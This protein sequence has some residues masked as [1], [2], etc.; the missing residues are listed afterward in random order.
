M[1][2]DQKK[3]YFNGRIKATN[4]LHH[5]FDLDKDT[6]EFFICTEIVDVI[7]G[8]LFFCDDEQLENI[9]TND[10]EQN[11]TNVVHKKF[12]EKQNEKK[13]CKEDDAPVY[14]VTIKDILRFDLAMDY[15]GIDLKFRQTA[16]AI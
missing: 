15:V 11:L 9:D 14:T 2:V 7:I 3:Q 6:Y 16:V 8:D 10:G 12:I 1:S 13:F 5:R 4:T